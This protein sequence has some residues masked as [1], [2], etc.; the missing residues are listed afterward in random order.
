MPR[1]PRFYLPDIP[2]H[3]VQRGH[4]RKAVFYEDADYHAYLGWLQEAAERYECA[5]HSYVLMTNHVHILATP[6]T[7]DG[8]SRMMQYIGR[9]YVP[10]INHTYGTSGTLWEGRYKGSLVQDENLLADLHALYRAQSDAGRIG[11]GPHANTA[12][13]VI[14]PTRKGAKTRD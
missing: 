10:Y 3:I 4:S 6:S 1:K 9:Q 5:V 12:G 11:K 8:V 14:E 13:R 2:V 7:L